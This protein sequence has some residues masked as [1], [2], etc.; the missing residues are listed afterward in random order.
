MTSVLEAFQVS[1]C[2]IRLGSPLAGHFTNS[3]YVAGPGVTSL[4]DQT[5]PMGSNP[6]L[7]RLFIT[8]RAIA[9]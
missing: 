3:V 5:M 6:L 1:R 8:D 4:T 2:V 7:E 9:Y